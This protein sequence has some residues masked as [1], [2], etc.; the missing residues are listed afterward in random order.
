MKNILLVVIVVIILVSVIF[1]ALGLWAILTG[2]IVAIPGFPII[3]TGELALLI[4]IIIAVA[5]AI[6]SP[7]LAKSAKLMA[8]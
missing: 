6:I 2:G 1:S 7:A 8:L 4:G 3:I 5:V